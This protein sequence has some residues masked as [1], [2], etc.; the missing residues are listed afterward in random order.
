MRAVRK[1]RRM[2]VNRG[3]GRGSWSINIANVSLSGHNLCTRSA[4]SVKLNGLLR[5]LYKLSK[6]EVP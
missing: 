1:R 6:E 3:E 5:I 4:D 2:R